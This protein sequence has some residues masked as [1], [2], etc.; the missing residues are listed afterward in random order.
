MSNDNHTSVL[1]P[2]SLEQQRA[3]IKKD[4]TAITLILI[5]VLAFGGGFFS[6]RLS[7]RWGATQNASKANVSASEIFPQGGYAIP[8]NF[9][10]A[11]PKLLAAGAIDLNKLTKLYQESGK[12]LTEEQLDLLTRGGNIPIVFNQDN[13]AFLLNFFW[14]LGLTNDNP[15]LTEG[16]MMSE[17]R[18]KAGNFASTGGWTL[19]TKEPMEL[20]AS[21]K[22]FPLNAEQ[23]ALLLKVASSVYR[24]CCNNPTHFPD[25]NHGM[26]MLGLLELMAYQN[27]TEVEM[28]N[29]AKYVNA[30]WFPQQ[31]LEIAAYMKATQKVDFSD[32]EPS[33]VVGQKYSSGSGY[34]GVHQWLK[35][36][37][38]LEQ[39]PSSGGSCAVQ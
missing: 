30:Y 29:A 11:G 10:D 2:T 12:P 9:G 20:Y 38:M 35:E 28:F 16:Q 25:C 7:T 15:I 6:G 21:E 18:E 8:A 36:N 14:A 24:P 13:A 31:T 33:Q 34:A 22:I 19:G 26:A 23:Q 39:S 37:G 5:F 32:A 27:A 3:S 4:R 1:K 17:G